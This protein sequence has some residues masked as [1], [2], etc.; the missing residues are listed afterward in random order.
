MAAQALRPFSLPDVTE[1]FSTDARFSRGPPCH[2]AARRRQDAR[3][4]PAEHRRHVLDAEI[5][6]TAGTADPLEAADH[7]LAMRTVLEEQPDH[8]PRLASRLLGRRLDESEALD[9]AFVLEDP[10]N[11]RLQLAG[12]QIHTR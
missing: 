9:I 8:L 5:H 4:E 7:A 10:R 3:A 6:A 2:D 1:H 11:L 12:R